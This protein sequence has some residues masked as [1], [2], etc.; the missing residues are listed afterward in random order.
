MSEQTVTAAQRATGTD[1]QGTLQEIFSAARER[2]SSLRD[3]FVYLDA[4]GG[5]QTPDE[6]AAA[7][8]K[9]LIE[10]SGN[11]G[12]PYAT[13]H[14]IE[15]LVEQARQE[16][17]RFLGCTADEV[18]FGANMTS[19]NFTMSR[20]LGRQLSPGD[21]ILVTRLDH[22]GNVAPWLDLASDLGL[23]VRHADVLNDTTMDFADVERQLGPRTKVVAFPW[24]ANSTGTIVDASALVELA[25]RAG[26]LA[27]I[28]AVQYAAHQPMD[29]TAVGAD[30]V[31]CSAYKFCG[32]HLGIAYGRRELLESWRPYKA[33][34]VS[35]DPVGHRFE[36]GTLPYELLGG[37]LSAFSY[38]DS[39]GGML[40]IAAWERQLGERLLAGLP[41]SA[42]LYGLGTMAG[43]VPTFL[44]N[45]PGVPSARLSTELAEAG[46]GVWSHDSY[47]ALGL[48][49]RIGWGEALRVGLAH[50]NTMDE[51]DK[52]TAALAGLVNAHRGG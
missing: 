13:S 27:W 9:V 35:F 14:R 20:T 36:T 11:M 24:A 49:E 52:F 5:T 44:I 22:D 3:G 2:F 1:D 45:F 19:L 12:A 6:V 47:Y 25:H 10:A 43:R 34:P 31:M 39:L 23:V 16:S 17:A 30:V 37:L 41:P 40:R 7:V 50:Y 48:H 42:R 4:P 38:L 32:P 33:R 46:F 51:I 26:A 29:V 15:A 18:I 28:D 21:E 8:A